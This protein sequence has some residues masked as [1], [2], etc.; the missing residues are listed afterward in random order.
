MANYRTEYRNAERKRIRQICARPEN[1]K[2]S[3]MG[4][5]ELNQKSTKFICGNFNR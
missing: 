2:K 4:A 5:I 3:N 1:R